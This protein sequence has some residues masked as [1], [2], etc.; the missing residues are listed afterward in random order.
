MKSPVFNVENAVREEVAPV[1]LAF[2]HY[3]RCMPG[4]VAREAPGNKTL[5][6]PR[7]EAEAGDYP[8]WCY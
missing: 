1:S 5:D 8:T 3:R 6:H 2:Y 7:T 4:S